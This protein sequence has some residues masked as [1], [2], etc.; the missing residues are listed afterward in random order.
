MGFVRSF[1]VFC[2]EI[3]PTMAD[4]FTCNAEVGHGGASP[5]QI[6]CFGGNN[7]LQ[8]HFHG[9]VSLQHILSQRGTQHFNR[10]FTRDNFHQ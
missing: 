3:N 9:S 2:D 5:K 1:K 6:G 4:D 10:F 7:A 8:Y